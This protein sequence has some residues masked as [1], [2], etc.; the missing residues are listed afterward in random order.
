MIEP[1]S[2]AGQTQ[3]RVLF[4]RRGGFSGSNAR[5]LASLRARRPDVIFDDLDAKIFA[6][7]GPTRLL[8]STLGAVREYGVG[9]LR[10]RGLMRHRIARNR[11]HFE[12][13]REG[14]RAWVGARDYVCSIQT[15][16]LFDAATG[17]FPNI[18]YTDHVACAR[19]S[20]VWSDGM[21]PP[22]RSWL[23]CEAEIYRNAAHVCTFGS[24]I[25]Q[26]LV[27]RYG[28]PDD[29]VSCA[30]GGASVTPDAPPPTD[31]ARYARRNVLFVGVDWERKGGPDLLAAFRL[32]RARL[33]AAT[34]TIVGCSPPEAE[35]VE[36]CAVLGKLPPVD[37]ATCYLEASCFCMPSRFEPFG[38][39]YVEAAHFALPVIATTVGDI[40]DMVHDGDNGWRA[41]PSDPDA[42]ADALIRVLEDP[43]TAR[44]MGVAGA[45]K[46]R[47]WTWDAV[48]ERIL[49]HTPLSSAA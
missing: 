22:S 41:P 12:M 27:Y 24:W 3:P 39:V 16:S 13:V 5:L 7:G 8:R 9:S 35:G 4:V 11:T 33:P 20:A 34:L 1:A 36:G 18:V 37:V 17:R 15:Q 31:L 23:D 2:P 49:A 10:S 21:G 29:K 26:L 47:D 45:A 14:L 43:E 6:T 40:G 44:R 46:A 32:L 38:V 25:R 28:V 30:G 19:E 48:A 42:L